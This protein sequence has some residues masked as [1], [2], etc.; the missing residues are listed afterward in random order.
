MLLKVYISLFFFYFAS[1]PLLP[2]L[3]FSVVF[4]DERIGREI[5]HSS[6]PAKQKSLAK[7]IEGFDDAHWKTLRRDVVKQG[8]IAKVCYEKSPPLLTL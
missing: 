1:S 4:H 2:L 3:N 5:M 7:Q 6:N 8:N